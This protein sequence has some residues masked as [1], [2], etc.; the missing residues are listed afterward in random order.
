MLK[1]F[2][3][4][5]HATVLYLPSRAARV[6]SY[7]DRLIEEYP[8]FVPND[9]KDKLIEAKRFSTFEEIPRNLFFRLM[10]VTSMIQ[11]QIYR[12]VKKRSDE[13]TVA[14]LLGTQPWKIELVKELNEALRLRGI[15]IPE[16]IKRKYEYTLKSKILEDV[17]DYVDVV[18]ALYREW[19]K[20]IDPEG[21]SE[22][23]GGFEV[24]GEMAGR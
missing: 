17:F 15:E 13:L 1:M 22:S 4:I 9:V 11:E 8:K 10:E 6:P 24:T 7:I 18:D 2:F 19:L 12:K 20:T 23:E 14:F 5:G 3:D 16:D 21:S